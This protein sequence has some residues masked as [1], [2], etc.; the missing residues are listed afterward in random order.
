LVK[1]SKCLRWLVLS[2]SLLSLIIFITVVNAS[3][4]SITAYYFVVEGCEH[5]ARVEYYIN[6]LK[7]K[8]PNVVFQR[9]DILNNNTNMELFIALAEG[10]NITEENRDIPAVFLGDMCLIGEESIIQNLEAIILNYSG[11]QYYDRAGEIVREFLNKNYAASFIPPVAS[12]ITAALVDSLNPCAFATIIILLTYSISQGSSRRMLLNCGAFIIGVLISYLCAGIGLIYL[13][14]IAPSRTFLRYLVGSI[15]VFFAALEFKEFMFY[16]RGVSLEQP[17][18]LSRVLNRYSTS[19]TVGTSFLIGIAVSMI[20][21]PC[22]GGIYIAILYLLAKIGLTLEIFILLLLYN[23]I[24]VFPL[25]VILLL[26]YFGRNVLEIDAWR[27]EKR[28]YMRLIAGV[29]LLVVGIM[30]IMGLI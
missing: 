21:L 11:G 18:A 29:F 13:I 6:T 22:T 5:C 9:F 16:G 20:E 14:N 4:Q 28:R 24:F 27:I 30:I 7:T 19:I 25:V 26:V 15:T 23:L 3:P 1:H 12:V 8:Y 17:G 2:I 10:F